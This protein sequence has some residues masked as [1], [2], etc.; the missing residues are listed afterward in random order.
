LLPGTIIHEL[1]HFLFATIL[2]VPTGKLTVIPQ[3]EKNGEVR[4]GRLEM[5]QTDPFRHSLIGLAPTILGI[6][7]IYIIGKMSSFSILQSIT[8]NLEPRTFLDLYLLTIVSLTMFTSKKDLAGLKIAGPILVLLL[9]T[10][11]ITGIRVF[12][13]TNLTVKINRI[14][15]DLNYYLII[16]AVINSIIFLLLEIN[17]KIWQKIL[18]KRIIHL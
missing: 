12:F 15:S 7:I 4:T 8:Y 3:V 17:F 1:S 14:I 10:L 13:D 18:G 2:R 11:Y 6:L 5:A 16:S 9:I